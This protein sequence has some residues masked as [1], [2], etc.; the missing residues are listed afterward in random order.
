ML[1]KQELEQTI[2]LNTLLN[3][4]VCNRIELQEALQVHG[5]AKTTPMPNFIKWIAVSLE[6]KFNALGITLFNAS[7]NIATIYSITDEAYEFALDKLLTPIY[8]EEGELE[9]LMYQH[10]MVLSKE[11]RMLI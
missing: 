11:R 5:L 2:V 1:S 7:A 6:E 8:N 3:R 9:S 4:R 10:P